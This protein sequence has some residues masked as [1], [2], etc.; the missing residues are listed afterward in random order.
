MV[1]PSVVRSG[2]TSG[3]KSQQG[4]AP[5]KYKRRENGELV[6][7]TVVP[8]LGE[9]AKHNPNVIYS[10]PFKVTSHMLRHTYVSKLLQ[11][12][13]SPKLVQKLVGHTNSKMTMD[14]Y[15]EVTQNMQQIYDELF[16]EIG[17]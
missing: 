9:K 14:V 2:A 4:L 16:S 8:V 12:G 1:S 15:A 5:R 11:N 6:E 7:H 10:I 13:A 17:D 3:N